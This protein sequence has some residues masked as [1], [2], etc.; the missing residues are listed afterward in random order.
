MSMPA[1]S[2]FLH[3]PSDRVER[4]APYFSLIAGASIDDS[5]FDL[6]GLVPSLNE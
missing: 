6:M 5:L 4:S 3:F 1:E 2:I